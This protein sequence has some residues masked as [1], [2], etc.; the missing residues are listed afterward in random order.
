MLGAPHAKRFPLRPAIPSMCFH[1]KAHR[2]S[3][4]LRVRDCQHFACVFMY[5]TGGRQGFIPRGTNYSFIYFA[6]GHALPRALSLRR[7]NEHH[8]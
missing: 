1:C 4:Q 5:K 6:P 3:C 2:F 8:E 7:R